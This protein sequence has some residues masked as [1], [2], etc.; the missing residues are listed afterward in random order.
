MATLFMNGPAPKGILMPS[1][2]LGMAGNTLF[3]T[4]QK[5]FTVK[6]AF[7]FRAVTSQVDGPD[8]LMCQALP[9]RA[10]EQWVFLSFCE[11][12]IH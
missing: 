7:F 8:K 6:V 1:P 10:K 4:S 3:W 12:S 9:L 11:S 2:Q 5:D